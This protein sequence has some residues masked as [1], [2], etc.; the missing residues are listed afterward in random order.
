MAKRGAQGSTRRCNGKVEIILEVGAEGGSLTLLG[1][2]KAREWSFSILRD[3]STLREFDE[4]L[5]DNELVEH[6]KTVVG[7]EAALGLLDRYP[8]AG[9]YPLRVHPEFRTL[10]F[11]EVAK[12]LFDDKDFHHPPGHLKVWLDACETGVR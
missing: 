7:F 12:R 4:D 11:Y 1:R 9:L 5:F 8:W 6:N 10:V 3:E 2:C